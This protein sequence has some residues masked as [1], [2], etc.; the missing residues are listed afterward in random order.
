[1][2]CCTFAADPSRLTPCRLLSD[3]QIQITNLCRQF[4]VL[5]LLKTGRP[6]STFAATESVACFGQHTLNGTKGA[7]RSL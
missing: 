7:Q 3:L 1:M 4:C 6:Y 5:K 2:Q